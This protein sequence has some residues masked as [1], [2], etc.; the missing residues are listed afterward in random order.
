MHL[1][2]EV[3]CSAGHKEGQSEARDIELSSSCSS[4]GEKSRDG[5]EEEDYN[6]EIT[7]ESA[8]DGEVEKW[9]NQI[10][11]IPHVPRINGDIPSMV[12]ITSDHQRL[13][14]RL[15]LYDL[16]VRKVQ[17]DGNCQYGVKI[18]LF[19]CFKETY[20]IEILPKEHRSKRAPSPS[21]PAEATSP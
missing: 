12:E 10:E 2:Q 15:Q 4:R 14:N 20:S 19:S 13:L 3:T 18:I 21:S 7:D 16:V 8:W 1:C 9:L 5:E 17:G 6:L 11:P